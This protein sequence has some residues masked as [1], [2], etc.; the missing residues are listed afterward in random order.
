MIL[1]WQHS[2]MESSRTCPWPRVSSRTHFQVL[3]LVITGQWNFQWHISI[4]VLTQQR[5]K[6]LWLVRRPLF[7]SQQ[8]RLHNYHVDRWYN[9]YDVIITVYQTIAV[10]R[11]T[12]TWVY[13]LHVCLWPCVLGHE[14]QV[15]GLLSL[16]LPSVSLT[17]SLATF[18]SCVQSGHWLTVS[19][20]LL[21][22]CP[23]NGICK[24]FLVNHFCKYHS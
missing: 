6:F 11:S 4:G 19:G 24:I 15:L 17:P 20:L 14:S 3:G 1:Q 10:G 21:Q 12:V 5:R 22:T 23:P 8:R 2:V 18:W 7:P 9:N 16:A 13:A